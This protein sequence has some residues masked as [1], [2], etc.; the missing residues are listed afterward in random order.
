MQVEIIKNFILVE[1]KG[2]FRF[3]EEK[4]IFRFVKKDFAQ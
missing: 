2:I 4:V 1:E 3:V